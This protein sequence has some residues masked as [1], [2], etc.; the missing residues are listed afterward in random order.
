M[1]FKSWSEAQ[2]APGKNQAE[3]KTAAAPAVQPHK[4]PETQQ[5]Q[6]PPANKA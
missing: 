5:V 3:G 1:S 4:T 2:K 6:A